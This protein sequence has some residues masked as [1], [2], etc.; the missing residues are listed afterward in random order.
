MRLAHQ[1]IQINTAGFISG[2]N[3]YMV[4]WQF[5]NSIS[6][7]CP[8]LVQLIHI[9][10]ITVCQHLYEFNK[11]L[12]SAGSIVHRSVMVVQRNPYCLCYG[13]QFE[14]VQCRKQET[15]HTYSIYIG[16][17]MFDFQ[18]VAVLHN[19]SHIEVCIVCNHHCTLA[20]F[21]E[22]R[23]NLFD[24]RSIHDH[25][26]IDAGKLFDTERNRNFGVYKC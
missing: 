9:K 13:I 3:N 16:K 6:R 11:N 7:N 1:F 2:K 25:A 4:C 19:E 20:E 14:S 12:C 15:C 26:V 23:Q 24:G 17:I 10:D 22:L 18:S 21:K 8:L 5:L